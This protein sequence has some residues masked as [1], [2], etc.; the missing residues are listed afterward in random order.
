M[1]L[2]QKTKALNSQVALNKK[3][4]LIAENYKNSININLKIAL[5]L[6]PIWVQILHEDSSLFAFVQKNNTIGYKLIFFID[7]NYCWNCIEYELENL[8][9]IAKVNKNNLAVIAIGVSKKMMENDKRFSFLKGN[10]F[11]VNKNELVTT[12]RTLPSQP[13]YI[14]IGPKGQFITNYVVPKFERKR[15]EEFIWILKNEYK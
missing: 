12:L 8:K 4:E 10:V 15:F 14:I 2:Y 11:E 9:S 5:K 3:T 6:R 7:S 13:F 1:L